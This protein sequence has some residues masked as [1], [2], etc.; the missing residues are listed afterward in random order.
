[1]ISIKLL[2]NFIEITRRHGRSPVN[3]LHIFRTLFPRNTS[4]G[5]LLNRAFSSRDKTILVCLR[6]QLSQIRCEQGYENTQ[7]LETKYQE[8]E[9]GKFVEDSFEKFRSNML[10]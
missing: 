8:M 7:R 1:M 2:C 9:Q 10:F 5:M 3:L 6:A 4:G